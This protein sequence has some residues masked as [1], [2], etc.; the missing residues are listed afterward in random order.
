ML[1]MNLY[2][3]LSFSLAVLGLGCCT[4]AFSGCSKQGLLFAVALG[5]LTAVASP[6]AEDGL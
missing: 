1:Q 6:A 3:F 4:R 2:T 5:L